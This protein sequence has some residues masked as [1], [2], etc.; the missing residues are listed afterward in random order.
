M[1]I[2]DEMYKMIVDEIDKKLSEGKEKVFVDYKK[3]K[4]VAKSLTD[5]CAQVKHE[6]GSLADDYVVNIKNICNMN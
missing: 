1:A 4:L 6:E 2:Q 3:A 5:L